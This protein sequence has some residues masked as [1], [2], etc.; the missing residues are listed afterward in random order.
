M[1]AEYFF[2]AAL[3]GGTIGPR[4]NGELKNIFRFCNKW[5]PL[6]QN[7]AHI[8]VDTHVYNMPPA[9]RSL[10]TTSD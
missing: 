8:A 10:S 1:R 3:A 2:G 6:Q 7:I 9:Q 5:A 4:T